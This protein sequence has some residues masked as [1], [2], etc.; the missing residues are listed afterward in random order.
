MFVIAVTAAVEHQ[1]H[2]PT[3]HRKRE[4]FPLA[5]SQRRGPEGHAGFWLWTL[6]DMAKRIQ[7]L[8]PSAFELII[9]ERFGS[10]AFFSPLQADRLTALIPTR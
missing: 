5:P 1:R 2:E 7:Q 8:R 10:S 4:G 3:A 6:Y 9:M